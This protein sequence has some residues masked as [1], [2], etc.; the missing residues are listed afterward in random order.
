MLD[1]CFHF[2][3]V[4]DFGLVIEFLLIVLIGTPFLRRPHRHHLI[5]LQIRKLF[6]EDVSQF[7]CSQ[8]SLRPT[9]FARAL[10]E[11]LRLSL[12]Q[13]DLALKLLEEV[14]GFDAAK[15][16]SQLPHNIK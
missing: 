9:L 8:L 11:L 12:S 13:G 15:S 6:E 16:P 14:D 2:V 5:C 1:E 7:V 4:F 3:C 10:N